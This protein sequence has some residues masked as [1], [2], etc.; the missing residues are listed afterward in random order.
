MMAIDRKALEITDLWKKSSLEVVAYLMPDVDLA[1]EM[2]EIALGKSPVAVDLWK[3][4]MDFLKAKQRPQKLLNL[5][6]RFCR[7]FISDKG[8]RDE[9]LAEIKK[10]DASSV[11]VIKWWIDYIG[12]ERDFPFPQTVNLSYRQMIFRSGVWIFKMVNTCL[13]YFS[14]LMPGGSNYSSFSLQNLSS[15]EIYGPRINGSNVKIN[16]V[17]GRP[18]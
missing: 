5:Y 7:L 15:Y 11:D 16:Y 14:R 3:H 13:Q 12:I 6:S 2:F 10:L 18:S 4:Y 9:Y 8:V 1:I 17:K